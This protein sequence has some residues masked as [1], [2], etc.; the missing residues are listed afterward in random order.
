MPTN[1]EPGLP[2]GNVPGH[3]PARRFLADA[4]SLRTH[5]AAS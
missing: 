4:P 2:L 3:I 5:P 1:D